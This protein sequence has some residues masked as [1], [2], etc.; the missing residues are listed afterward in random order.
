MSQLVAPP[1][2]SLPRDLDFNLEGLSD[3]VIAQL[4][5]HRLVL[6]ARIAV[7]VLHLPAT[8]AASAWYWR[9]PGLS[10]GPAV[11]DTALA[12]LAR[13]SR[14]QRAVAL[15]ALVLRERPGVAT[16]REAAARL[17]VDLI[18]VYRPACQFF[19]RQPFVGS[20]TYRAACTLEGVVID[21]RSGVFP[22]S[23]AVSRDSSDRRIREDMEPAGTIARLATA[24][25]A[26]AVTEFVAR[27]APVL[28]AVPTAGSP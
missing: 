13:L 26:A 19:E 9:D 25:S 2:A 24:A 23:G 3:S 1:G 7:A 4:L 21:V 17:Q 15:P 20:I 5:A 22:Y 6:P 27:F 28:D 18:L 16:L 8:R 12:A 10:F 11:Q 14:V